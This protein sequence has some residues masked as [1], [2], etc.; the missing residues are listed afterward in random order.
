MAHLF[1]PLKNGC[2]RV[3]YWVASLWDSVGR[4]R[5][6]N[7]VSDEV[8]VVNGTVGVMLSDEVYLRHH[9]WPLYCLKNEFSA[10]VKHLMYR[11]LYFSIHIKYIMYKKSHFLYRF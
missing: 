3:F 10:H 4:D 6:I 5:S 7:L 9:E 8:K 2:K 1:L 11:K